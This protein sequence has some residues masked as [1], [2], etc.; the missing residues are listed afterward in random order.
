MRDLF[1]YYKLPV[2]H[3]GALAPLVR[4]MQADLAARHGVA[5]QLKQRPLAQ[6]GLL[7]WMEIYPA[8]DDD[9][10]A[11]LDAAADAAGLARWLSGPRRTE[12]FMDLPPCA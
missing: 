10:A 9:F 11:A 6:E 8:V 5:A 4:A 7:T 2:Q 12:V 1:V 3:A